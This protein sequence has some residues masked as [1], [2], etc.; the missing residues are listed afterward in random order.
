MLLLQAQLGG[1]SA[2]A[3]QDDSSEL[4]NALRQHLN[5]MQYQGREGIPCTVEVHAA[6]APTMAAAAVQATAESPGSE[7]EGDDE[8][9]DTTLAAP[10]GYQLPRAPTPT[11]LVEPQ[12]LATEGDSR[13]DSLEIVFMWPPCVETV[14]EQQGGPETAAQAAGPAGAAEVGGDASSAS[15]QAGLMHRDSST[16]VEVYLGHRNRGSPSLSSRSSNRHGGSSSSSSISSIAEHGNSA[17]TGEPQA[18]ATETSQQQYEEATVTAP[19]QPPQAAAHVA[20]GNEPSSD[21]ML[22]QSAASERPDPSPSAVVAVVVASPSE[23]P[24]V[25]V[26][27]NGVALCDVELEED[28]PEGR[29]VMWVIHDYQHKHKLHKQAEHNVADFRCTCSSIRTQGTLSPL[30]SHIQ[31]TVSL[32]CPLW[33]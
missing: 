16:H 17:S 12:V 1:V 33:Q 10:A 31:N 18:A 6:K 26:M 4:S 20:V 5:S 32:S 7:D 3:P 27:H 9:V 24:R 11:A 14:P 28:I 21:I 2:T 25:V 15:D 22:S 13:G 23:H 30:C 19:E 8:Q 29:C